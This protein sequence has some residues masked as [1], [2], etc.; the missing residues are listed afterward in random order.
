MSYFAVI[1]AF[2]KK[3]DEDMGIGTLVSTMLPFSMM[4][5]LFWTILLII[6]FVVG[7]PIGPGAFI[8]M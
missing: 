7:L 3:Y 1:I 2:A 5:L 6:W 4:F 8:K